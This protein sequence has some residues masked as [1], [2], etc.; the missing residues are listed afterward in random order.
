MVAPLNYD[1]SGRKNLNYTR[2]TAGAAGR[3]GAD[4][5]VRFVG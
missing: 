5:D 4:V 3:A 1:G 2:G